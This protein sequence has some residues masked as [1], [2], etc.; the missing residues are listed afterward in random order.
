MPM[1]S[2]FS[3]IDPGRVRSHLREVARVCVRGLLQD[4]SPDILPLVQ[5]DL[6]TLSPLVSGKALPYADSFERYWQGKIDAD[7]WRG[8]VQM[9]LIA[10]LGMDDGSRIPD[11]MWPLLASSAMV[12]D[13]LLF[14]LPAA[15][16][17]ALRALV[18]IDEP[19][20]VVFSPDMLLVLVSMAALNVGELPQRERR[21]LEPLMLD[22][23]KIGDPALARLQAR[24]T[25]PL[26][27]GW[28]LARAH[29][30][31]QMGRWPNALTG[32]LQSVPL[33]ND[34]IPDDAPQWVRTQWVS[35]R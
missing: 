27:D 5:R 24:K 17:D 4:R 6:E 14:E 30:R 22:Y 21:V 25:T 7:E 26:W 2:P 11:A 15:I 29:R 33:V 1:N 31:W 23:V 34:Q 10:E 12:D 3:T 19:F 28:A 35:L 9:R 20:R 32:F 18:F 13:E 8:L 16:G